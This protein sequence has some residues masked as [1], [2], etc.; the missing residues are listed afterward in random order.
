[1]SA[2][3]G[4]ARALIISILFLIL[5][6]IVAGAA[7]TIGAVIAGRALQGIG[8]SGCL[9]LI[10][11]LPPRALPAPKQSTYLRVLHT[12]QAV[13]FVFGGIIGGAFTQSVTWVSLVTNLCFKF[14]NMLTY[15]SQRLVFY[16]NLPFCVLALIAIPFS[17]R[18]NSGAGLPYRQMQNKLDLIGV[19]LF[20]L[21][22]TI[23]LVGISW[24]G[25][26]VKWDSAW[27][28]VPFVLG[29]ISL[30]VGAAWQLLGSG[31]KFMRHVSCLSDQVWYTVFSANDCLPQRLFARKTANI[32]YFNVF[33]QSFVVSVP[34]CHSTIL[35]I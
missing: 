18:L 24:S 19:A 22:L 6:S 35:T 2:A 3:V 13:G 16:F 25:I 7:P 31:H 26:L 33:I 11:I 28:I 30:L 20:T 21:S 4:R 32:A 15:C 12:S 27:T 34:T 17:F 10:V 14:A 8:A 23:L 29:A 5:G 9:A 1:M